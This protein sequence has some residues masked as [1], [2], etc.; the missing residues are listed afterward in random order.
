M[1]STKTNQRT[2][3]H[4]TLAA[5]D[6]RALLAKTAAAARATIAAVRQDQLDHATPC[7]EFTVRQLLGHL[8][9]VPYAL[10][11]LAKGQDPFAV[12]EPT[13]DDDG[14]V[15]TWDTA[16]TAAQVAWAD[17]SVLERPMSLPWT[18]GTGGEILLGYLAEFVLHTWDL[19]KAT[20]QSPTWDPQVVEIA[21]QGIGGMPAT[22]RHEL[23]MQIRSTMPEQFRT[24]PDPFADAIPVAEDA[25][26][27]DRLVAWNGRDPRWPPAA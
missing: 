23:F 14:W 20:G 22:N 17:D 1:T 19:A 5:D 4:R 12:Q 6:P 21:C 7:S 13:S 8:A 24:G 15:Q 9:R 18:S 25:P 26:A 10:A 27:I 3:T 2:A 11:A 16:V